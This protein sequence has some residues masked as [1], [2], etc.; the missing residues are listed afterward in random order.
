MAAENVAERYNY[1]HF[2]PG[3][4]VE[5]FEG[6]PK[7]GEMAWD[8]IMGSGD[9][10]VF[11]KPRYRQLSPSGCAWPEFCGFNFRDT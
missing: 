7:P 10:L 1:E 4:M 3:L 2:H 9:N 6:G 5:R 8:T 11:K